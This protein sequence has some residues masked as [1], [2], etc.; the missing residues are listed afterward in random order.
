MAEDK[1][2]NGDKGKVIEMP[3]KPEIKRELVEAKPYLLTEEERQ[4]VIAICDVAVKA[5]GL[6]ALQNILRVLNIFNK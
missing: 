5:T 6:S 4:L 3:N 1:L 2:G